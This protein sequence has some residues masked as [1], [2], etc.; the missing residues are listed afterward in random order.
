MNTISYDNLADFL[1]ALEDDGD[2]LRVAAAV[3]SELELAAITRQL[4]LSQPTPPAVLFENVRGRTMPVL[5]NLLG[6]QPRVCR[7][8]HVDGLDDIT[9]RV[10]GLIQPELPRGWLEALKLA[11]HLTELTRCPPVTVNSGICQQV[12]RM[13]R[14]V[15]LSKLPIP[16]FWP[17]DAGASITAGLVHTQSPV[18]GQRSVTVPPLELRDSTTLAIHW[19]SQHPAWQH[20]VE[21]RQAGRQMP[22]AISL[23]GDPAMMLAATAPLPAQTDPLLLAGVFRSRNIE[24]VKCR[25]NDLEVPATAEMILEGQID[26]TASP[27]PAGPLGLAN[28]YYSLPEPAPLINVTALTHRANPVFPAIVPAA[29]PGEAF[30]LE[31]ALGAALLPFL[32]LSLPELRGLHRPLAGGGKS[33]LFVSIRKQYPG[34]ARKVMHAL[35]SQEPLLATKMLVVVDEHVDVHDEEQ[36]WAHVAAHAHMGRDCVHQDGPTDPH[37]HAAPVRGMGHK[38]GI[39]ATTKLP[40]E[41]HPRPWPDTVELSAD[42]TRQV[43][44]RWSE[45]GLPGRP[46]AGETDD[47]PSVDGQ[48]TSRDG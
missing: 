12:V 7:A 41:G 20:L 43:R 11:P 21:H 30:W 1:S 35:W 28:G 15:D 33:I 42:M 10:A 37:D 39:D 19:H 40:E 5:V 13:G 48:N 3:D 31:S 27:S 34:Q 16:R 36:V 8:L 44:E 29:R 17:G 46:P 9:A 23:G 2:L 26:V 14:D 47:P 25:S 22:V 24:L 4:C 45:L 18:T 38:L 6:T 32:K